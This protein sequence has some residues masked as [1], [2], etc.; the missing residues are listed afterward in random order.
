MTHS[1]ISSSLRSLLGRKRRAFAGTLKAGTT[2]RAKTYCVTIH[3]GNRNQRIVEC[4]FNMGNSPNNIFSNFSFCAFCHCWNNPS[5]TFFLYTF[6]ACNCFSWSFAGAG[7]AASSLAANRQASSMT[8]APV[9]IYITQASDILGGLSAKLTSHDVIAFDYLRY[10][11][12]VVFGEFA[13]LDVLINLGF[14]QNL[15]R[16]V[17]AYTKNIG[18]PN[19]YRLFIRNINTDNTR[20]TVPLL[21]IMIV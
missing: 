8:D 18:K 14:S 3:I 7:I 5:L 21:T 1:Y 10:P 6:F 19:P 17:F 4:R 20:H 16:V 9:T 13:A 12:K 15:L 11:A 2:R